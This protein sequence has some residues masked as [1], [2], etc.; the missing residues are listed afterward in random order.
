MRIGAAW[1]KFTDEGKG[2]ISIAL[3]EACLPLTIDETKNIS[4]WEIPEADRKTENS[5]N[6]SVSLNKNKQEAKWH[7]NL[8]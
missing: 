5:P 4:L 3:D 6:Y 1:H 7:L 8:S 2:Y